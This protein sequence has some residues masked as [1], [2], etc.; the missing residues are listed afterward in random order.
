ML[1]QNDVIYF[2]LTDRFFNGDPDNN[3]DVDLANPQA[4]HGGDFAGIIQKIP[5]LKNLG[6]STLWI[7]PVY[8]NIHLPESKSF[9]YHGYW[10]L[11]F[12][13]V[14]PHLYRPTAGRAP[15]DKAYLKDLVDVLHRNDLKL[16]LD[17]VVNHTGYNHPALRNEPG[18][19]MRA[20]WFNAE[21]LQSDEEGRM[22][23]LPDIDQDR[24]EVADY[25]VNDILDW[26]DRTDLDAIRMDTVKH[27]ER[28]FWQLYKQYVR[29]K[30][31]EV[32]LLGE[33]LSGDVGLLSLYQK[34]FAFDSVFDFPLQFT[35]SDV[36][37]RDM[38]PRLLARPNL[39]PFEPPGALD[40]DSEYTNANR[41]VTL[42]DNHDLPQRFFTT[43]LDRCG[44][45]EVSALRIM[46]LA[47]CFQLT[48]RGIPQLYYGT[49]IAMQGRGDPDNRRDMPWAI[50]G[51]GL[52]PLPEHLLEGEVFAWTK[53][54][55]QLRRQNEALS[56][57][58][59]HTL[60]VDDFVYVYLREFQGETAIVILNNGWEAMSLP[61]RVA[62]AGNSAIPPRT[63]RILEKM[64]LIDYLDPQAPPVHLQQGDLWL[65]APGK[66]ARVYVQRG[67]YS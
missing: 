11:H 39:H 13:R 62:V 52:Q 14:D 53:S 49:E 34:F 15:G 35:L 38:S 60:Y 59:L 64:E 33:V 2:L 32:S 17:M 28:T 16:M 58:S 50:F 63:V 66:G 10:P 55:L 45:H 37:V 51:G 65:A 29:G 43:C 56:F 57:G 6:V 36:F 3:R 25:F 12:D 9:G 44:G 67:L 48:T 22:W 26:I 31:P 41:L 4:Y 40:R 46:K 18:T 20:D 47:L 1:R 21:S 5:Y 7:T 24:A 54:L 30:Y 19:P 27:V 23:G 61:L 42:L 8:E